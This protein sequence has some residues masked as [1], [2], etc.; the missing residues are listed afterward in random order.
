M[1]PC[2]YLGPKLYDQIVWKLKTDCTFFRSFI[3]RKL[4]DPHVNIRGTQL[5]AGARHTDS[6]KIYKN[7]AVRNSKNKP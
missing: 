3:D 5:V 2:T 6:K 7:L 1:F 4:I